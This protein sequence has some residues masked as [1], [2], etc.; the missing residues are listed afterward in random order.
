MTPTLSFLRQPDDLN[1]TAADLAKGGL[2]H[3]KPRGKMFIG[4]CQFSG[5]VDRVNN[6]RMISVEMAADRIRRK[7]RVPSREVY[8]GVAWP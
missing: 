8:R 4:L 5:D 6:R 1:R 3:Q 7:R 2:G